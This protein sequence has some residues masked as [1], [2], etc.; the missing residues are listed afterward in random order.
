MMNGSTM[1]FWLRGKISLRYFKNT[2]KTYKNA[3]DKI[4]LLL[5]EWQEASYDNVMKLRLEDSRCLCFFFGKCVL[6][7]EKNE[8][9][10]KRL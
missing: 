4:C 6:C 10:T 2:F 1:K 3:S 9:R 7:E 8:R 5:I